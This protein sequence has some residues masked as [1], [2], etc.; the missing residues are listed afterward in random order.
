MDISRFFEQISEDRVYYFFKNKCE[1]NE[2]VAKLL[3]KFCCVS[4]GPKGNNNEHK[5][6]ARGFATSSR[7][8]VW[9]N[10]DIFI[11]LEHLIKKR[12]RGKDPRITIYV[13]DIGITASGTTKEYME[14]LYIEIEKLFL[15]SDKNQSLPLNNKKKSI[16]SHEEGME[17]LGLRMFRNRLEIGAKTKSKMN[18]I[19]NRLSNNLSE[20]E[21]VQE[22]NRLRSILKYKKYVEK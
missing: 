9:C 15:N 6:I 14:K 10:L 17:I 11:K 20:K 2:K 5:T 21:K 22:K 19:K 3:A 7:L 1:C 13:D 8:A 16:K 12:L 4:I 18:K